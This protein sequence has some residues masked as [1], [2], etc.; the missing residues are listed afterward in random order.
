MFTEKGYD[1]V[2]MRSIARR[3]GVDPALVH[4][5]FADKSTL[6]VHSM[7]LPEDPR[8]VQTEALLDAAGEG[9]AFSGKRVVERFLA[10]WEPDGEGAGST[11][12]VTVAQ[13]MSSSPV[14]ARAMRD[15]L[16]ERLVLH[17]LPGES[18]EVAKRRRALVSSQLLGLGWARY[19]IRL[20][21]LASASRAEVARWAGETI[22]RYARGRLPDQ[23]I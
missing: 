18:E 3:A 13:A 11:S 12:F 23:Q 15:F 5:Y 22:D 14:A 4:H 21:P 17:G 16:A 10:Q 9:R 19:V 6:F 8:R 20:E 1:Q 2:S 7:R